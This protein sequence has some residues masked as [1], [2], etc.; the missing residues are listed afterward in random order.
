MQGIQSVWYRTKREWGVGGMVYFLGDDTV[1][2]AWIV[3]ISDHPSD[4]NKVVIDWVAPTFIAIDTEHY[5]RFNENKTHNTTLHES[6]FRK[7]G[8]S[9]IT[10]VFYTFRDRHGNKRFMNDEIQDLQEKLRK[11]KQQTQS[12]QGEVISKE[13]KAERSRKRSNERIGDT[14][15]QLGRLAK[16][17]QPFHDESRGGGKDLDNLIR[18]LEDDGREER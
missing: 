7:A 5:D 15:E 11:S 6:E 4:P 18:Q 17:G 14:I 9:E 2:L 10:D 8:G 13:R 3:D 12:L 16:I 1:P